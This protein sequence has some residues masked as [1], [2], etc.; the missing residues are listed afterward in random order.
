MRVTCRRLLLG[1]LLQLLGLLRECLHQDLKFFIYFQEIKAG[2]LHIQIGI[3]MALKGYLLKGNLMLL[4]L[5]DSF[6]LHLNWG[7][8]NTKLENEHRLG[9][10]YSLYYVQNLLISR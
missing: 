5:K 8:T 3:R 10:H 9:R 2:V 4:R 7:C 6:F 1:V